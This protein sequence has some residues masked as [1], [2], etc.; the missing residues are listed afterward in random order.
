MEL[1]VFKNGFFI[2]GKAHEIVKYLREKSK[3]YSTVKEMLNAE[4]H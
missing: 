2:A 1:L 4:R 3:I